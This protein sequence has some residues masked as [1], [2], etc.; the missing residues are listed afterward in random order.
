M[1]AN[2]VVNSN[3][4]LARNFNL[5]RKI[6]EFKLS[7]LTMRKTV[8]EIFKKNQ[9]MSNIEYRRE[10]AKLGL[11]TFFLSVENNFH[12]RISDEAIQIYEQKI[13][14]INLKD[15]STDYENGDYSG[16][17][18]EMYFLEQELKALSE[19][20]IVYAYKHFE[21]KLK[22]LLSAAYGISKNKMFKWDF[23]IEFL[24]EKNID[25]KKVKCYAEIN[26]LRNLNNNLKHSDDIKNDTKVLMIKEFKKKTFL[27]YEDL[28]AFY[29]RIENA[30]STFIY[31][32][33]DLIYN[34]L[35]VFDENRI[36]LEAEKIALRMTEN[37]A[38]TLIKKLK[39]KY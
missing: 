33:S 36:D 5:N 37:E 3:L 20:K 6:I 22:F 25:V 38:K 24:K 35:Y 12:D 27:K 34:D 11:Q 8:L 15:R 21:N 9:N 16:A 28:L 10:T 7:N 32:L 18:I 30:P 39:E 31:S 17:T 13:K 1:I 14:D 4:L 23:V 26:E 29:K 2:F 19:M